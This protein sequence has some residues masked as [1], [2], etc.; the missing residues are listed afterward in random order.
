MRTV[1]I[2]LVLAVPAACN[3][4][5]GEATTTEPPEESPKNALTTPVMGLPA[6]RAARA[7]YSPPGWPLKRGDMVAA[8]EWT[9]LL[10]Q[11]PQ[12]H[13]IYAPFW[14]DTL[15]FGADWRL[16]GHLS[17]VSIEYLGHYPERTMVPPEYWELRDGPPPHF[18][19]NHRDAARVF[20]SEWPP[21]QSERRLWTEE[22]WIAGYTGEEVR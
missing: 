12:W 22:R 8:E 2:F 7:P 5:P 14:A 6:E 4:P 13:G 15:L 10:E 19:D 3:Y 16:G 1:Q 21:W 18:E 9:C 17:A 20:Y 11:F